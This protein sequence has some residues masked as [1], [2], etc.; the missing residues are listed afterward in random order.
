MR[1]QYEVQ[2]LAG[3]Y[4][5]FQIYNIR[6]AIPHHINVDLDPAFHFNAD[7][8]TDPATHLKSYGNLRPLVYRT[9]SALF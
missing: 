3:N 5:L 8:D 7:P 1:N 4:N 9:S 6:V 2:Y